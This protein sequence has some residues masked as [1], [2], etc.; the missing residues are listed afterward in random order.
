LPT[1]NNIGRGARATHSALHSTRSFYLHPADAISMAVVKSAAE[2]FED[3]VVSV[4]RRV[5]P[6]VCDGCRALGLTALHTDREQTPL[7]IPNAK[8]PK[9]LLKKIK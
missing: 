2:A 8:D 3:G 6:R 4:A 5:G 9:N 1:C 7:N